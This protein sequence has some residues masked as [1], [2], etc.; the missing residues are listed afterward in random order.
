MKASE[1]PTMTPPP[2]STCLPFAYVGV[3]LLLLVLLVRR[4]LCR[5]AADSP[6]AVYSAVRRAT[7]PTNEPKRTTGPVVAPRDSWNR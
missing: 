1:K 2:A 3:L 4:R 5:K 7:G 6:P